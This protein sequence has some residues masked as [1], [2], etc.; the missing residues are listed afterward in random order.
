MTGRAEARITFAAGTGPVT[1]F[2]DGTTITFAQG[3]SPVQVTFE[4]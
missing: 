4:N 3:V 1:S 2:F